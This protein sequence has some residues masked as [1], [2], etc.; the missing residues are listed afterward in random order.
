MTG[1][2]RIISKITGDAEEKAKGISEAADVE[3]ERIK[4]E[5]QEKADR[6]CATRAAECAERCSEM[7][8]SARSQA[9]YERRL[10]LQRGMTSAVDSAF[11]QAELEI[12]RFPHEKYLDM[13]ISM[14]SKAMIAHKEHIEALGGKYECDDGESYLVYLNKNDRAT[15]GERLMDGLRRRVVGRVDSKLTEKVKIADEAAKISGGLI[16]NCGKV[17]YDLSLEALLGELRF[18]FESS[19]MDMLF[20]PE[21]G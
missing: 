2:D 19:V 16:L 9:S 10:A 21:N 20:K 4:K 12:L 7:I 18:E 3:C 17:D 11:S 15:Y 13:L 14:L 8:S 5:Y 6:E 1:I